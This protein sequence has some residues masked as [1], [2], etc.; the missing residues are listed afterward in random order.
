MGFGDLT[1]GHFSLNEVLGPYPPVAH[2]NGRLGDGQVHP[3]VGLDVVLRDAL[4]VGVAHP[5]AKLP[6]VVALVGCE[7]IPAVT[8]TR[9]QWKQVKI[10]ARGTEIRATVGGQPMGDADPPKPSQR[11]GIIGFYV[12]R[13]N[14]QIKN[15][16]LREL[17]P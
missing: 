5:E 15:I 14:M 11:S 9:G 17:K 12:K 3:H 6:G 8:N 4:A 16:R 13:G 10:R 2:P 1:S 7:A